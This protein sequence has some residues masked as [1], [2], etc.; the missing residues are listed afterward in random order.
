[1]RWLLAELAL[2]LIRA[3][4]YVTESE[5]YRNL[6]FY[7]RCGGNSRVQTARGPVLLMPHS[8]HF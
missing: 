5:A 6:V 8:P 4:F 3:H 7:Y 1:M 2:P